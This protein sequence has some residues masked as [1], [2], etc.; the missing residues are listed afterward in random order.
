MSFHNVLAL[1]ASKDPYWLIVEPWANEFEIRPQQRC[2]LVAN[3]PR[4]V[5]SLEAEL[6]EG[7]LVIYVNESGAT[8]EFWRENE[9]ELD[10]PVPIPG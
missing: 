1:S 8:F 3:H 4:L 10:M 7:K 2:R 5:P 9:L 6:V